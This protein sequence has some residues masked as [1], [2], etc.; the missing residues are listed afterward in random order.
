[1]TTN[2]LRLGPLSKT[3]TVKF[4]DG[5]Y[6]GYPDGSPRFR[7]VKAPTSAELAELTQTL[8]RHLRATGLHCS[9]GSPGAETVGQPDALPRGVCAQQQVPCAGDAGQAG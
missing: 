9:A 8:A 5:V 4:L 1:M 3:E 6:I 2:K 7:W